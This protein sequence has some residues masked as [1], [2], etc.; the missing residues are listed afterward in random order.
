MLLQDIL[1]TSQMVLFGAA[2]ALLLSVVAT[3]LL[4]RHSWAFIRREVVENDN[5]VYGAM[6]GAIFAAVC[7]LVGA[8]NRQSITPWWDPT[9]VERVTFTLTWVIYGQIV[10]LIM[11]HVI[12]W[13]LFGLTPKTLREELQRD[14]NMSVAAVTGFTYL[15]VSLIVVFRIL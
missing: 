8:A 9:L 4:F 12:N 13:I 10:S 14:R 3:M 11:C 7:A 5:A 15:G 1:E 2:L 6:S